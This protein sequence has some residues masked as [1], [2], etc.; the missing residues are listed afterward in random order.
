V[1][2]TDREQ[3]IRAEIKRLGAAPSLRVMSAAFARAGEQVSTQT[4]SRIYQRL[5]IQSGSKGGRP[6]VG[7]TQLHPRIPAVA[8]DKLCRLAKQRR[9]SVN[10][11]ASALIVGWAMKRSDVQA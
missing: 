8:Y 7:S 9:V 5:S 6:D 2:K 1:S 10:H 3:F 4:V 11:V